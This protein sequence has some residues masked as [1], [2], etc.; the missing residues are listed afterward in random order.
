MT[1]FLPEVWGNTV[2]RKAEPARLEPIPELLLRTIRVADGKPDDLMR[3]VEVVGDG[4]HGWRRYYVVFQSKTDKGRTADGRSV[5]H[6]VEVGQDDHHLLVA[7]GVRL[8]V[9][10]DLLPRALLHEASPALDPPE[11]RHRH[12]EKVCDLHDG[13]G[14]HGQPSGEA[15]AIQDRTGDQGPQD[16]PTSLDRTHVVTH[17]SAQD[18]LRRGFDAGQ[19]VPPRRSG[20]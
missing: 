1:L 2:H 9:A 19:N 17:G 3:T 4:I 7:F 5:I 6:G 12:G 11:A 16:L 10:I 15:R 20:R 13:L 18:T 8:Q 14:H